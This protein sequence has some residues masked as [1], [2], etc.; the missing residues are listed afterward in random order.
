MTTRLKGERINKIC[1]LA[2]EDG[3]DVLGLLSSFADGSEVGIVLT[4]RLL[5]LDDMPPF[6]HGYR[7]FIG[8][9]ELMSASYQ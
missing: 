1:S 3:H 6:V 7:K 2:E 5:T 8:T 9:I 4:T